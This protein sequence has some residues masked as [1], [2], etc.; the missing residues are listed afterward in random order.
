[1]LSLG[2]TAG[3]VGREGVWDLEGDRP[4]LNLDSTI[5]RLYALEQVI[6]LLSDVVSP[7][8]K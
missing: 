5:Y 8:S 3:A 2:W 4:G 6:L 1:M 7:S